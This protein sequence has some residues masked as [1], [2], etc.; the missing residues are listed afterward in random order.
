MY[1]IFMY[2]YVQRAITGHAANTLAY[3]PLIIYDDEDSDL[4][5]KLI[6]PVLTL[7]DNTAG[8]LTFTMPVNNVGYEKIRMFKSTVV[9][10]RRKVGPLSSGDE[11]ETIW[12]GR[13]ITE[14]RDFFNQKAITCEGALA[15]LNDM[16]LL[17]WQR[18]EQ[19]I[20]SSEL[21]YNDKS[22]QFRAIFKY[23]LR[24]FN[25]TLEAKEYTMAAHTYNIIRTYD[26]RIF[27][28]DAFIAKYY[29]DETLDFSSDCGT[30]LNY[31]CDS[32]IERHGGHVKVLNKSPMT[33]DDSDNMDVDPTD[34]SDSPSKKG[35]Y[36]SYLEEYYSPEISH[37]ASKAYSVGDHIVHGD[38]VYRFIEDHA[39]GT[40]FDLSEVEEVPDVKVSKIEFQKN[41]KDL[42][43][44]TDVADRV[45]AVLMLGESYKIA[46][47]KDDAMVFDIFDNYDSLDQTQQNHNVWNKHIKDNA[48]MVGQQMEVSVLKDYPMIPGFGIA[49]LSEP[50]QFSSGDLPFPAGSYV[51]K[52]YYVVNVKAA[53]KY[54]FIAAKMSSN[55][56]IVNKDNDDGPIPI[57]NRT[58][59]YSG[60]ARLYQA[61]VEYLKAHDPDYFS[62]DVTAFDFN[63]VDQSVPYVNIGDLMYVDSPIHDMDDV[64]YFIVTKMELPLDSPESTTFTLNRDVSRSLSSYIG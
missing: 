41:L 51:G 2:E 40:P 37:D 38:K 60:A 34:L 31:I 18:L 43:R 7:E 15:Y 1:K 5:K 55:E 30:L 25:D 12:E 47:R 58:P 59:D 63:F 48:S 64:L 21:V 11:F 33:S 35:L 27:V 4:N 44:K 52:L 26:R 56:T 32:V 62:V 49:H 39:E 16:Y 23:L 57:Q 42:V 36:V 3:T 28:N 10:K 24:F 14:T 50:L 19:N 61:G 17:Q 8:S 53:S 54:G 13:V 29:G 45:T 20:R 46:S 9:V 22:V 6:S